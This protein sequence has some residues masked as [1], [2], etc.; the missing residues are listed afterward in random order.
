MSPKGTFLFISSSVPRLSYSSKRRY[1]RSL[2]NTA[3][4]LSSLLN[5][6][7]EQNVSFCWSKR[8]PEVS[9]RGEP[10]DNKDCELPRLAPCRAQCWRLII[11]V[12]SCPGSDLNSLKTCT[13]FRFWTESNRR[14]ALTTLCVTKNTRR[15][16]HKYLKNFYDHSKNRRVIYL[17]PENVGHCLAE[18]LLFQA[19]KCPAYAY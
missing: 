15:H 11:A 4:V 13:V 18:S 16:N 7:T 14:Y 3:H 9:R 12:C 17:T 2:L 1:A 8:K 19:L 10:A 6:G 5:A